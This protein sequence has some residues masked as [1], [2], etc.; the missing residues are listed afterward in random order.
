MMA[1][2]DTLIAELRQ[3]VAKLTA[4]RD[5]QK[6]ALAAA[7]GREAALADARVAQSSLLASREAEFWDR[8]DHQRAI[9]D[10]LR[11]MSASRGLTWPR[12][13]TGIW[14]RS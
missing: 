14:R 11:A 9:A 13:A 10:V 7:L 2:Q 4:E 5:A 1:P 6:A 8:I 12:G 3:T